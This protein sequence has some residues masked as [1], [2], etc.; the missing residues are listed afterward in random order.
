MQLRPKNDTSTWVGT[1]LKTT[2]VSSHLNNN[3]NL[4]TT[5]PCI[6]AQGRSEWVAND[7]ETWLLMLLEW[8]EKNVT[9]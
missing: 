9:G 7:G 6:K 2:L 4:E 1:V 8:K 5:R 3:K